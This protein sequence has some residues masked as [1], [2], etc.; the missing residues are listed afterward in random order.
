MIPTIVD[1]RPPASWQRAVA[2]GV[3]SLAE[4]L[5]MLELEPQQLSVSTA[6]AREFRLRV[7]RSFVARM[8]LGDPD[9][10]LLRQVVPLVAELGEAHGFVDDPV[11]DGEASPLPGVVHKYRGRLLLL[12][13]G[14]CGIH[15]RYCFRRHF[16]YPPSVPLRG[17]P[18]SVPLR[19]N[20]PSVPLRGNA[21][22]SPGAEQWDRA[23]DYVRGDPTV[24]EVILSGGDPLSVSDRRLAGLATSLAEIPH[25]RRLRV[26]TRMPVIVPGRVDDQLLGWLAGGRLRP[27]VVLHVNHPQEIDDAV[28][29]SI[30]RLADA[31]VALYNQAVLLA[32]I[33]DRVETLCQLSET[34]FDAG[35]Q[36]YYLHLLDRVRGAAHFEV[37]ESR[38]RELA[39]GMA[40]RLP[41]YLVPRVVRE[42]AGAEAKVPLRL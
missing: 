33:N 2:D 42:I 21:E 1:R 18:P 17:N 8:R 25:L 7:P 32:G 23:L 31:G 35:V 38:A 15:C 39:L 14:A 26:H 11:G 9:D 40:S 34:L 22:A 3:S 29:R 20:P 12:V 37:N 13:T 6:A 16:P 30:S 19:G 24:T 10:P 36:P 41:G 4:L 27:I 28:R 5:K